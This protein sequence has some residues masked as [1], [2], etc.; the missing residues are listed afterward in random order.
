MNRNYVEY[1]KFSL[2]GDKLAEVK[3]PFLYAGLDST[4][5]RPLTIFSG[6][7]GGEVVAAI[8]KGERL[9]V[10]LGDKNYL[11]IKTR[12]NLLGWLKLDP[13]VATREKMAIEGVYFDG[14]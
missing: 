14:D 2:R 9:T 8:A 12:E 5:L 6:K 13:I 11:L 4:A 7:D 1:R 3:Q 10:V